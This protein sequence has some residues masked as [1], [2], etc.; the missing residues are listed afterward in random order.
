V[1]REYG[2]QWER[3]GYYLDKAQTIEDW[4]FVKG[5]EDVPSNYKYNGS[6]RTGVFDSGA[7]YRAKLYKA[8]KEH[9]SNARSI[10]EYGCGIGRN[11]LYLKK[12]L[13]DVDVYGYELCNEGVSIAR[14]AS[15]KFGL[16]ISVTELDYVNDSS[17]RYVFPN[18]DL[19]FTMFSLE[20][21]PDQNKLALV[22]ILQHVNLG[23]IHL[24]PV[25]ENYPYTFGGLLG[26]I[27]SSKAN[28]LRHFDR[29]VRSLFLTRIVSEV[30][31]TSHNP[32]M[33]P[34][35]YILKK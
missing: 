24:E 21:L 1:R 2:E 31:D 11:L 16:S 32:V 28:Y 19:G 34:T 13:P 35:L 7:Y 10:T 22:N 30:L 8:I 23:S 4:L 5:L 33:Y 3:Y 18:T 26:R 9:F 6:A 15:L 25:P 20:Q 12:L 14:R 17:L 27:Y 29:N